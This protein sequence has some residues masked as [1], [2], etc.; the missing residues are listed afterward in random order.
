MN[1]LK[2]LPTKSKDGVTV[3]EVDERCME[4]RSISNH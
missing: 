4:N 3:L 2:S 1:F